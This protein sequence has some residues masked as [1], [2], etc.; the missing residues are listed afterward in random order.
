M[1]DYGVNLQ[2]ALKNQRER[3]VGVK[4]RYL[5]SKDQVEAGLVRG[6]PAGQQTT[7]PVNQMMQEEGV[8]G[9]HDPLPVEPD[10]SMRPES[11]RERFGSPLERVLY[12]KRLEKDTL[13]SPNPDDGLL[14]ILD[15]KKK[16][17][18]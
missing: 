17:V 5:D 13:N 4:Q 2:R 16:R 12:E 11:Q 3:N 18:I 8:Y 6:V 9:V 15:Y 1:S 10:T 14:K 7:P